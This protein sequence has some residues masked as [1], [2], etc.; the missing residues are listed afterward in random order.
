MARNSSSQD[1]A[2]GIDLGTSSAAIAIEEPG[3]V[4]VL[5]DAQGR[6]L[7]PT[8][9][10][11]LAD[12]R[13]IT[14]V[15]AKNRAAIA[16]HTTVT[17]IKRL[18]GRSMD[19]V[20][21]HN[22]QSRYAIPIVASPNG[23]IQLRVG[24][25][26]LTPID[27]EAEIL[28]ALKDIGAQRLQRPVREAV[29]TVPA[30]FQH[31]QREATVAAATDAGIETLRLLNEPTAAALAYGH[32][33]DSNETIVIYDFGGGTFDVTVLDRNRSFYEVRATAGR[34]FLGG[35]DFDFRIATA[36]IDELEQNHGVSLGDEVRHKLLPA[37]E[38]IKVDLSEKEWTG[39]GISTR[40]LGSMENRTIE[41]GLDRKRFES[42]I[43][44][45]VVET[46]EAV[47]EVL[48][49]A[50]K[51]VNDVDRILLVGGSTRVPLVRKM[52]TAYF[53][54]RPEQHATPEL[55]VARGA[56]HYAAKLSGVSQPNR[57]LPP[58]TELVEVVPAALSVETVGGLCETVVESNARLPAKR[59]RE[60]TTSRDGQQSATIRIFQGSSRRAADNQLLGEVKL[61]Q[62][63]R[64]MRGSS[65]IEVTFE[66]NPNGI[67][68][69]SAKELQTGESCNARL[70][71]TTDDRP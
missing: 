38:R 20:S 71:L 44:P 65:R 42:L 23:G 28:R 68:E 59:S 41:F 69:V 1:L 12:G 45:I 63:P 16:P 31:P 6:E 19:E 30:S 29:I 39:A 36:I 8:V 14:G 9:V 2:V 56:A 35:D 61:E 11:Y 55:A 46:L 60:Y 43:R 7:M 47:D 25:R 57:R 3:G 15:A 32:R 34:P 52:V 17:S 26:Q 13:I 4:R 53:G 33:S 37:A 70:L 48:A 10:S 66:I 51:K 5:A 62:L 54:Q 40:W 49:T 22:L 67:L 64:G 18:I 50:S 24:I 21:E 58:E 27:V